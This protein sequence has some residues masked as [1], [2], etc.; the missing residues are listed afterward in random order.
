MEHIALN[1]QVVVGTSSGDDSDQANKWMPWDADSAAMGL[2]SIPYSEGIHIYFSMI[3][4]R[5]EIPNG[6]QTFTHHFLRFKALT[7]RK[8]H[9]FGKR[10]N[11][12]DFVFAPMKK[13]QVLA[14]K[15]IIV[16]NLDRI[17]S[18]DSLSIPGNV[19]L[20]LVGAKFVWGGLC[21]VGRSANVVDINDLDLP[22]MNP[23]NLDSLPSNWQ[24]PLSSVSLLC[25]NSRP[26]ELGAGGFGVVYR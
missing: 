16:C 22:N 12:N 13:F 25:Y 6:L 2:S 3:C 10:P 23:G 20:L 19:K 15:Y 18:S 7:W 9:T 4:L 5:Q 8:R 14:W 17:V 26:I 1:L 24:I 21:A 11:V